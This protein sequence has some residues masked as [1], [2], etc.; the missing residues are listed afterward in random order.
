[1]KIAVDAMG[2][3]FAPQAIVEGILMAAKEFNDLEFL[4]FGDE[5]K[6]RK[7]LAD[8]YAEDGK[9]KIVHTT[10]K[11]ESDD[12]PVKAIRRKKQASMVLAAQAVKNNEADAL[13]S[14]GNTG[15]LLAAGLL[16]IGR[17]KGIDRPGLM[18]ILPVIGKENGQFL[19]MDAGANADCKP[20]NIYQFGLLGSYYAKFVQGIENPRIAL[21]NNGS[22]A[23]K[24]S[25][26]SK[27]AYALLEE[28]SELNFTG[29]VE[30]REILLGAADVVVTDGFTGNAVLKTMEGT[31][32]SLLKLIKT[33]LLSGGLKTKIG[34]MLIKDSFAEIKDTMDYSKHGGAV[35]FGLRAPVVK[36]HGSADK[37]AVYHTVKQIRKIISSRV[38]DDVVKHFDEMNAKP[39]S[40]TEPK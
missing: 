40:Q 24:G 31:A 10:E 12:E 29:N 2:G 14:A 9:I 11:I 21:L 22:E 16:I 15:A 23:T 34:G 37:V 1:M 20:E 6:I 38:I 27:K 3:D 8:Q 25:E 35:L 4:L 5:A 18:P 30:A 32:M 19:L 26:L 13:F 39:V 7:A 17:I 28:D 36:T 33:Q